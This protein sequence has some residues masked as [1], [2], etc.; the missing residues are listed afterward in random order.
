MQLF[1]NLNQKLYIVLTICVLLFIFNDTAISHTITSRISS[2]LSNKK[3]TFKINFMHQG[4]TGGNAFGW[5]NYGDGTHT[6]R[7]PKDGSPFNIADFPRIN[8]FKVNHTYSKTGTYTV[9]AWTTFGELYEIPKLPN[10]VIMTQKINMLGIRR[11]KLYFSNNK[12]RITIKKNQKAPELFVKIDFSGSG[13]LKGYWEIEGKRRE[14]VLQDLSKGSSVTIQYPYVPRL[15]TSN[16]GSYNVRFVITNPRTNIKF[17][18]A[19]YSVTSDGLTDKPTEIKLLQPVEGEDIAY[20]PLSFKWKEVK[21]SNSYLISIFSKSKK[22][23]LFSAR[24]RK[25]EYKLK[26]NKLK[27]HMKPGNDYVWDVIGYNDQNEITSKSMSSAFSFNQETAFLPGQILFVT[28][29]TN[30]GKKIIQE[31]KAK[32]NLKI[33]ETYSVKTIGLQVTKFYT[34]KEIIGIISELKKKKG[35]VSARPN[36]IFKTMSEPMEELQSIK[37]IIKID[38]SIPFK[39]KGITVAVIDTGVDL[40]HTD[41]RK[42]ISSYV[43][44]LPDSDYRPEIHGTAVAG[45]IGARTNNF[46]INGY[47]PESKIFALR[48]CKQ[49]SETQ[50]R[51]ECY[52]ASIV[53]ALDIAIQ[54]RVQIINMSLGTNVKDQLISRLIEAGSKHGI[55]FVAP[56]GNN[57]AVNKLCFPAS[58]PK[59]ISVAGITESGKFF[60]NARVAEKSDFYLPCN[61]LFSTIPNNKHNFLS[62]TSLSSA[63]VSGLLALAREKN[64]DM[65]AKR[66]Q[67]FDGDINKWANKYLT[68]KEIATQRDN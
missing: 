41:L 2:P 17:P 40:K 11:G 57:S 49:I 68:S 3:I 46:G 47:A 36:Y 18:H 37:K 16:L 35:V 65:M 30:Q 66:M 29:S 19:V 50:P 27:A 38:P 51:G 62:G 56:A 48:A 26:V 60:P 42:A 54:N 4:K 59:V 21:K 14:H 24:T 7:L 33:L 43:N 9:K 31:A 10:P 61:N 39:G 1:K 53:K 6:E 52:S 34:D 28:K 22:Q 64:H 8:T 23:R 12:S 20:N 15:P 5:I 63:V 44:C 55:L 25:G 58:H 45:L 13:Y 67:T 32:Y